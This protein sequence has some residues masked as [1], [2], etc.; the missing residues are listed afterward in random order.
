[1]VI[2]V[3]PNFHF[4]IDDVFKSLIDASHPM[5]EFLDEIDYPVDLYCFYQEEDLRRDNKLPVTYHA[6]INL[7]H[8][9]NN[10]FKDNS[11]IKFGVHGLDKNTPPHSQSPDEQKKT[12]D[13]IYSEFDRLGFPYS[14]QVR[15]HEFSESYELANYF[16][17]K[18]VDRLF[19]TDKDALLWRIPDHFKLMMN[20]HGYCDYNGIKFVQTNIRL[21]NLI[22][23]SEDKIKSMLDNIYA[24][25]EY[26]NIMTHEYE[27]YR[28]DV[29]EVGKFVIKYLNDMEKLV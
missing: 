13:K 10:Y 11:Y 26:P 12:F 18:G 5:I 27:L 7:S 17:V 20:R 1:M 9:S 14:K 28:P 4:S 8:V 16:N 23:E 25:K 19:T 22:G 29:R 3:H 24:T 2:D 6:P 21:E 15:L